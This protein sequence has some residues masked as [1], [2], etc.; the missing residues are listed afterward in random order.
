MK[1][2]KIMHVWDQAGVACLLAKHHKIQGH[3]IDIY[4]RT[5]YDP[6]GI[7]KFYQVPE[8]N[9]DGPDFLNFVIEKSSSYD[10]IHIHSIPSLAPRIKKKIPNKKI[11]LH[12]HGSDIRKKSITEIREYNKHAD[13]LIVAAADLLEWLPEA[14]YIPIPVDTEHFVHQKRC[15]EKAFTLYSD[16]DFPS[17]SENLLKKHGFEL[18]IQY[19]NR[20]KSPIIQYADIPCFLKDFGTYVDIRFYDKNNL[21]N[22]YSKT[23]LE[24]LALGLK[25]LGPS[26][27]FEQNLPEIHNS[28]N[29]AEEVMLIYHK[30]S[31]K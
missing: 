11:V 18:H 13:Y 14:N 10:I 4:K 12:Y 22:S 30:L 2:L 15:S 16:S 5:G 3:T 23:A 6:F 21:I 8:L 25:V 26:L 9:L 17:K 31:S 29:V 19:I 27:K 28:K 1:P 7:L 20:L 24:C